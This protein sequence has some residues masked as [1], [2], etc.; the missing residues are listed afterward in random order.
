MMRLAPFAA[1]IHNLPKKDLYIAVKLQTMLTHSNEIAIEASYL[2]CYAI[3]LLIKGE[4]SDNVYKLTKLEA[5]SDTIKSW[6]EKIKDK[7]E[8]IEELPTP[9]GDRPASLKIAFIWA[10]YYLKHK[11]SYM[12]ALRDILLRGGDTDTNAAIIGGLLGA[13]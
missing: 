9:N 10:F 6:F 12:D 11:W 13:A 4:T 7:K 3:S 2:Y 5:K 1:W 8:S